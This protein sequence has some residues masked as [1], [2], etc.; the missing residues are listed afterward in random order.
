MCVF[1]S[2]GIITSYVDDI[3][4]NPGGSFQGPI[5]LYQII[6]RYFGKINLT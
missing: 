2:L 4:K 3:V 1:Y 6:K 5:Y